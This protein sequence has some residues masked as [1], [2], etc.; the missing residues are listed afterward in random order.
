MEAAG[1]SPRSGIAVSPERM[2][3]RAALPQIKGFAA[4]FTKHAE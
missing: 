1:V 4:A 2:C 3:E